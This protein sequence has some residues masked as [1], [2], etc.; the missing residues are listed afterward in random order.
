MWIAWG[1]SRVS[2]GRTPEADRLLPLGAAFFCLG[3]VYSGCLGAVRVCQPPLAMSSR[4]FVPRNACRL[5][6]AQ[7]HQV[8]GRQLELQP[9]PPGRDED[10]LVVEDRCVRDHPQGPPGPE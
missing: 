10:A 1:R 6:F 5:P 9:A 8:R 4:T 3:L 2:R 7:T